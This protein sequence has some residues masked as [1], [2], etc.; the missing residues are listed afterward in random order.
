MTSLDEGS[1]RRRDL[2]LKLHNIPQRQTSIHPAAFEPA[3][4]A[5]KQLQTHALDGAA[6]G[7]GKSKIYHCNF[8]FET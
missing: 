3:I 8:S 5:S 2:Y 4:T 7:I 6:S 1:T